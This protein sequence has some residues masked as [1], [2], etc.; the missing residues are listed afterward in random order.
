[1]AQMLDIRQKARWRR[2]MYAKPTIIFLFLLLGFILS[3]TW[4][5]YQKSRLAREN[6]L[7]ANESVANLRGREGTLTKDILRLSTPRGIEEELRSRYMVAKEGEGVIVI[8]DPEKNKVHT[9]TVSEGKGDE[10]S[11]SVGALPE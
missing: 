11:A 9:I 1:M 2:A 3:G 6:V 10:N 8:S 5:M 4:N 7:R